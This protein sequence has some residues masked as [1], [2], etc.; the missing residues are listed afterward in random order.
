MSRARDLADRVLHNRTHEDTDGGR[1]SI[2]TFKGEQSGGEISTLAQI[3][4]SHD[5]TS[6]DEKADLIFKTNDGSDGASPTE[7]LRINSDG[8]ID[9]TSTNTD[10]FFFRSSHST[11]TNF[12]ITNTNATTSNTAALNFAP[13]NNITGASISALAIE[14]F[15]VSANRTADLLFKTRK[16]GTLAERMRVDNVGKLTLNRA[17]SGTTIQTTVP[18]GQRFNQFDFKHGTAQKGAIWT[19]DTTALMGYYVP[20]GWGKN[21]YTGGLERMR[22]LSGGQLMV[23][24][25]AQ[26][27]GGDQGIEMD[28]GTGSIIT[29]KESTN[30]RTHISFVNPNGTIGSITTTGSGTAFNTSSDYR[31]KENVTDVTDGI[32]RVKQLAPKRFNFIVD[33]DTTVDGF[34][35]HEAA[36]VVPEAVHGTKDEVDDDDNA[37]MQGI[38]QSKLVPLLTAALQEAIA[39]IETLETE[40]TA[41]KERLDALEAE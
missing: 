26:M 10:S 40:N 23:G 1:E 38:D 34:L 20:S 9:A 37:V 13:A 19:D 15:S 3:Q 31:L 24:L 33:A 14:D 30:A 27:S 25:T 4:A 7:R 11:D 2:V 28:G 6:D 17:D 8:V 32:T 39:K 16:D 36:T 5:G 21:F 22:I 41:I 35:A 12:Y 29:G 18:D